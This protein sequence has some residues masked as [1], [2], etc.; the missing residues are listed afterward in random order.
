M[1]DSTVVMRVK[2][3]RDV[4][5]RAGWQEVRV[6]VPTD[7]D[8]DYIRNLAAERRSQ[9]ETLPGLCEGVTGMTVDQAA[10]I[11]DAVANQGS[12][13]YTTPSGPILTLLSELAEE[14]DLA[15]LSR[16]FI[17]FA[18]A[19][20]ANADFVANMVPPKISDYLIRHRGTSAIAM[21][22]W[23]QTNPNWADELK[24]ALRD[25]ARF[26]QAVDE[27]SKAIEHE[28]AAH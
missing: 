11:I 20:P 28:A 22:K 5:L 19:R 24:S 4:R 17:I 23:S 1:A 27:L 8:A 16:A 10:R 6:W 13:A 15:S 14:G 2:R 12:A 18:R 26:E 9:A 3:Q 21:V 7:Q 25:P